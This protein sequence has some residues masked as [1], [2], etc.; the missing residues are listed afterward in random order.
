MK[1]LP[2]LLGTY[3]FREP[4]QNGESSFYYANRME[5]AKK[6]P[7]ADAYAIRINVT[8]VWYDRDVCVEA[9][10]KVWGWLNS[11]DAA[12]VRMFLA[13]RHDYGKR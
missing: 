1:S 2:D 12:S 13:Y 6:M 5:K 9:G 7:F 8:L 11:T 4:A 3:S 10:M